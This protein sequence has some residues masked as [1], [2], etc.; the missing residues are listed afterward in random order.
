MKHSW[1][2]TLILIG[3]FVLAQLIGLLVINAYSSST[4]ELEINGTI[5]NITI[6]KQLP[7]GMQ[8][9]EIKPELSIISIAIS[10]VIAIFLIFILM[11]FKAKF[12]IKLWFFIVVILALG[13]AIN[14]LL[15]YF[16]S[17]SAYIAIVIALPLA[18][19][20]IYRRNM[21]VHNLTELLIYPGI[22][23]VF[24]PIL[25]QLTAI[26]LLVAI[27]IYDVWAVWHS[28]FMQKM[29]KYHINKL[30]IFPG[31]FLPNV[32]KKTK[33]KIQLLRQKYKNK[34]PEKVAKK[35]KL[36]INLA[37]LGGGDVVFPIIFSGVV[38][39]A[40]G[41]IPAL[42]ITIFASIA[43]FLLFIFARKGKFYPAMPF[44]TAGCLLGFLIGLL[45]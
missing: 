27:S 42:L 43:L 2:I 22:A 40:R 26:I 33:L 16:T 19:F 12:F 23:A 6:Q 41:L 39:L 17:Y 5:Q 21:L 3:M 38:L 28:G 44:L 29:A 10:M 32:D 36:K 34:I 8:P 35:S 14:S 1:K 37:I 31:F 7:Y 11:R 15:M 13:L 20:K 4:Q 24:V 30:N 18:I 9:P 25:S 45:F